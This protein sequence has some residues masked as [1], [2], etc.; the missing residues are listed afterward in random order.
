MASAFMMGLAGAF[1]ASYF[2]YLEPNVVFNSIS[3]SLNV[4]IVTL[5]GGIGL[6]FGPLVGSAVVVLTNEVFVHVFGEGNVLMSGVLLILF[7]LFMP[8]GLV[9]RLQKRPP[10]VGL[11]PAVEANLA[12]PFSSPDTRNANGGRFHPESC[13]VW[14][15]ASGRSLV[16]SGPLCGSRPCTHG[17]E[18]DGCIDVVTTKSDTTPS[19]GQIRCRHE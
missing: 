3:F 15:L 9:G 8:E 1:Y 19:A 5:I 6:L 16:T 7:M 14:L 18:S 4:L 2:A 13:F 12:H 10:E 11:A 17:R